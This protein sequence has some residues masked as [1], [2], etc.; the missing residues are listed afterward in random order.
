MVDPVFLPLTM[1]AADDCTSGVRSVAEA[2]NRAAADCWAALLGGCNSRSRDRLILTLHDLSEATV[3]SSHYRRVMQ[4]EC[5]IDEAVREGDGAEYAEA[6]VG[7]DQ[8][9]A[10]VLSR[11]RSTPA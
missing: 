1:A 5:R 3:G 10:T 8:A 7:Y 4:A 6:F 11:L 9:V 2:A